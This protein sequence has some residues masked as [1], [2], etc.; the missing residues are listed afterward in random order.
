MTNDECFEY[1]VPVRRF[2]THSHSSQEE[3]LMGSKKAVLWR[4]R[5]KAKR[6]SAFTYRWGES[7]V[8]R[9]LFIFAV[10]DIVFV[11]ATIECHAAGGRFGVG[12]IGHAKTG[13][14]IA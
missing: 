8:R 5:H 10:V 12:G 7:P 11:A 9:A 13:N 3:L 4:K 6:P 14:L 1:W 2:F